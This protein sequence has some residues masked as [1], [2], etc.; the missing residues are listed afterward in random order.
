MKLEGLDVP[1]HASLI[2]LFTESMTVASTL[3]RE[4]LTS[5]L[6]CIFASMSSTELRPLGVLGVLSWVFCFFSQGFL[7][8]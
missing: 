3:R 6:A 8:F 7:N 4:P 1:I 2:Q 5:I